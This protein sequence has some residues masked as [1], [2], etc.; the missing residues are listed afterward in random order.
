MDV[1]VRW[2]LS[3][4]AAV[5]ALLSGCGSESGPAPPTAPPPSQPQRYAVSSVVDGDT[6]R[7]SPALLGSTSL[8]FLNIDAP[9]SGG[10]TQEPWA[11][12]ARA[13]LQQL[14]PVPVDITIET[15]EERTDAFA[16]VLGHA[17]RADGMNVN[18]EQLRLGH[19]VLFVIWPNVALFSEYR[20]A[21][22]EA[23]A[24]GRGVWSGDA[25]L[26]EQPFEFRLR[27]DGAVAFRPVADFFTRSYVQPADYRLVHVNNRVFFN[28]P[29]A[30]DGAGYRACPRDAAGVYSS[31]C[32]SPGD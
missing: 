11:A 23:Q 14:L 15:D 8:R 18:R 26:P 30:A 1:Q 16:R 29:A 27:Q 2:R 32:F 22:I 31:S 6:I 9:E 17:I 3:V 13:H 19:A 20:S 21:Q 4:I 12:A 5:A 24:S 7:V 25:P 10:D 28:S